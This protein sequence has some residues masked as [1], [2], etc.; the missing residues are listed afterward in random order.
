MHLVALCCGFILVFATA[1]PS[2]APYSTGVDHQ[3]G[4]AT[5]GGQM[6]LQTAPGLS[7]RPGSQISV[8]SAH[9]CIAHV[10]HARVLT[11]RV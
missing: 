5:E 7:V 9:D 10:S 6:P 3:R 8:N 11:C 2:P 1:M 4:G